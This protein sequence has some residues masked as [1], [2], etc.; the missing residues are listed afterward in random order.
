MVLPQGFCLLFRL[1]R[2]VVHQRVERS[3]RSDESRVGHHP[4]VLLHQP[5]LLALRHDPAEYRL[6]DLFAEA[7]DGIHIARSTQCDW[8]AACAQLARPLYELM[9]RRTLAS[10]VLGTDD[11][12]VPLRDDDLDHIDDE[13]SFATTISTLIRSSI[14]ASLVSRS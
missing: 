1:F 11:T 4:T 13:T 2:I 9:V 5:L 7:V 10:K 12:T 3:S 8:M 14:S 6:E